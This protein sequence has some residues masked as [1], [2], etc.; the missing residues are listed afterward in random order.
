MQIEI[1][2][3]ST[4]IFFSFYRLIILLKVDIEYIFD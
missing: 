3:K 4:V 2:M 1:E